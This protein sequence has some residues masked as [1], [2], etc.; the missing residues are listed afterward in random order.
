MPTPS[1]LK[2]KFSYHTHRS[3][4]SKAGYG[5]K[6]DVHRSLWRLKRC[7]GSSPACLSYCGV[8][9]KHML[10]AGGSSDS[11]WICCSAP[12]TFPKSAPGHGGPRAAFP[13]LNGRALFVDRFVPASPA[14]TSRK[15]EWGIHIHL[16]GE[17]SS[18]L[19][20]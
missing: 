1:P 12:K 4:P 13:S 7:R 9:R 14:L 8:I 18:K 2:V 16:L 3:T 19:S 15:A 20:G 17:A 6:T 10:R 11:K 5:R